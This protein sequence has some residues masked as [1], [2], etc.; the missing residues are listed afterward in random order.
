MKER[1][2]WWLQY[3]YHSYID[4]YHHSPIKRLIDWA[5]LDDDK[6]YISD[7]V[8]E[9]SSLMLSWFLVSSHREIRDKSTKALVALLETKPH[10]M[11]K[12]LKQF[13]EVDDPYIYERLYAVAYG[14]AMRV[15]NNNDFLKELSEYVY[16]TIFNK[17]EVYPHVLLRDYASGIIAY[18]NSLNILDDKIDISKTVPPY[19]SVFPTIPSDDEIKSAH[20]DLRDK[21]ENDNLKGI[22]YIFSSMQVEYLR[23]HNTN[24]YGDFG[25]YTFQSSLREFTDNTKEKNDFIMDLYNIAIKQIFE[26]YDI[27]RHGKFDSTNFSHPI[28]RTGGKGERIGKKYQWIILHRLLAYVSD[29][30]KMESY[31]NGEHCFSGP[32]EA[33]LRDIDPSN[34]FLLDEDIIDEEIKY[35][36]WNS[37]NNVWLTDKSDLP[38]PKIILQTSNDEWIKL[39]GFLEWTEPKPF[40]EENNYSSPTKEL[41]YIINSYFVEEDNYSKIFKWLSKQDFSG[42]WLPE[43]GENYHIFNRESIWAPAAKYYYENDNEY[44]CDKTFLYNEDENKHAGEVLFTTSFQYT[45]ES[46]YDRS[47]PDYNIDIRK[48]SASLFKYFNLYYKKHEN[49]LYTSGGE[50]ACFN[51]H[52]VLY[53]KKELLMNF[54]ADKKLKLIW[55]VLG[56]K[57]IMSHQYVKGQ[58]YRQTISGS[59]NLSDKGIVNGKLETVIS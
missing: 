18:T 33:Y 2:G 59:Y 58:P 5:L 24:D 9:L 25:R 55:G 23:N 47:I 32:W 35:D 45:R 53:F 8:I 15:H 6:N 16:E 49:C 21:E 43:R 3:L 12:I 42:R 50:L 38:D 57:N 54:L 41:W 44:E 10:L 7:D 14:V 46:S 29:K 27:K 30:Y 11:I 37:S 52:D 4:P 34:L 51:Q 19:N 17:A 39:N 26:M 28:S 13:E 20:T 56:E 40:G 22:N 1:D 31:S 36:N 48:P